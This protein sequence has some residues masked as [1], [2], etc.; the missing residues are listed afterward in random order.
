MKFI[1]VI[2]AR[3]GSKGIKNKNIIKIGKKPLVQYTFEAAINSKINENFILSDNAK[4]KNLAKKF[5]INTQYIRPKKFSGSTTSLSETLNHFNKWL[6]KN[7]INYDYMVILQPTSPLRDYKDI[8]KC[9]KIIEKSQ[10]DSL[11][12]ISESLEH[13]YETI[14]KKKKSWK[15]V[16]AK[17]KK[18]YRRQDFDIKTYFINGAIFISSN[19]LIN[20]KK[21]FTNSNH[22][23]YK[24]PKNKS[25]EINDKEE[26]FIID[27]ILNR[28]NK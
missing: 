23:F 28:R 20:K 16:L 7:N 26:A 5:K 25:L 2:P 1:S 3:S 18:F 11:F 17:S 8:N 15:F 27:C 9:L 12:S 14:I 19:K 21:T 13:P 24:M 6:K 4:I 22:S 10:S